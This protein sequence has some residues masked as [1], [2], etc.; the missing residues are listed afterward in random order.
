MTLKDR[1]KKLE[2]EIPQPLRI[3]LENGQ[4]VV[5]DNPLDLL[6]RT[7]EAMRNGDNGWLD[8]NEA[9]AVFTHRVSTPQVRG[10][11]TLE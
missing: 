11:H 8:S 10:F 7:L 4:V 3:E 5:V 1:V 2:E 6:C 9:H